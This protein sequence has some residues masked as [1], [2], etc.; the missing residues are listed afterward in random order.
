MSDFQ[1]VYFQNSICD[2]ESCKLSALDHSARYG[3]G[4]FETFRY[5]GSAI[6]GWADRHARMTT[7]L[8]WLG[9]QIQR[10]TLW[11]RLAP[12]NPAE[13]ESILAQL[14]EANQTDRAIVRYT[15]YPGPSRAGL[16]D[17]SYD[18]PVEMIDLRPL[19]HVNPGP[20]AL[21]VLQSVRAFER[22]PFKSTDYLIALRGLRELRSDGVA[23]NSEGILL[24]GQG[25]LAEGIFSNLF[26]IFPDNLLWTPPDDGYILAGIT[27]KLILDLAHQLGFRIQISSEPPSF[28]QEATAIFTTN[29]GSG[30]NPVDQ[31]YH[32]TKELLWA[33]NTRN[34][35]SWERLNQAFTAGYK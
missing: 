15:V 32:Q 34:N 25:K 30:P 5:T 12:D 1:Q 31:V 35:P 19:P 3:C 29:S 2:I 13:L 18:N 24:T 7:A 22:P 11:P 27:R 16:A 28:L 33:G 14:L 9:I 20:R 26:A 8:D 21:Y 17:L 10:L 23:G 4:A 6:L